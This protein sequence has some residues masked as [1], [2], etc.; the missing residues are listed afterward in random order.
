MKTIT[1]HGTL[2]TKGRA[3]TFDPTQRIL[4]PDEKTANENELL[5]AEI[6]QLEAELAALNKIIN[7]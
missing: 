7:E 4:T 5:K 1:P 2:I 6:E 3:A